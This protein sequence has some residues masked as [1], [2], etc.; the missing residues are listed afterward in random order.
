MPVERYFV[1]SV[2][3]KDD[4]IILEGLEFHH[5]TNVMRSKVGESVEVVNGNG[6]LATSSILRIEKKKAVLGISELVSDP[7]PNHQ[8]I[9]LQGI[10]RLNRL[11]TIV[12][13][14]TELG[15]TE[16]WLF[17]GERSERKELSESQ[18]SRLKSVSVAAIKQC[19][20]LYLP[21]IEMKPALAKWQTPTLPIFFGDLSPKAPLLTD[22]IF[23][24]SEPKIIFCTGPESGF[25][26][27]E[28]KLLIDLGATGVKLHSNILRTDTASLTALV[29]ITHHL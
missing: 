3:S 6:T 27:N 25:S 20:R 21:Q 7:K 9:L 17:P 24:I 23:K 19:G 10:P 26:E 29:L 1:E 16:L 14:G 22:V 5:L 11:D 2:L 8:I 13:K 4:E 18:V 15:M 28:E 12:E